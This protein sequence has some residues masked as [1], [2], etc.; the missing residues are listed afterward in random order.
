MKLLMKI[1][2]QVLIKENMKLERT[3]GPVTLAAQKITGRFVELKMIRRAQKHFDLLDYDKLDYDEMGHQLNC[4]CLP[5]FS[6]R[7][8]CVSFAN[9]WDTL[10][11]LLT[12]FLCR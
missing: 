3:D 4:I 8:P 1:Q 7:N 11:P 2:I 10:D 5:P 12:N 9:M 6:Y